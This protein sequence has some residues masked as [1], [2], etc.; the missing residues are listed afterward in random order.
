MS[1][2]DMALSLVLDYAADNRHGYELHGRH[3]DYG[4][5]CAGLARL[6]AA[7]VEE[8]SVATYPDFHTWTERSVLTARGWKCLPFSRS[9][10]RR[11]DILLHEDPT[12]GHGHT[13]IATGPE[14]IVGAEGN[15]DGR[16]GDSSGVEIWN[17]AYS[18]YRYGYQYILRPPEEEEMVEKKENG[19]YR[20]YDERS[21]LHVFTADHNEASTLVGMGWKEEGCE[22]K[23]G[24]L[25]QVHR[26]YN[27]YSGAHVQSVS[28]YE[29]GALVI[30]GWKYE[31]VSWKAPAAGRPVY[32]LYNKHN[33]DHML[34][35]EGEE[36]DS[37]IELGWS[38]DGELCKG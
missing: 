38:N 21:G 30:Q 29:V 36:M 10:M 7:A 22:I 18:D 31:G 12:G 11:G 19:I 9:A 27:P 20:L 17:R 35:F 33:G 6:Y 16:P 4:T 5:D 23:C 13:V 26:L 34:L 2:V 8:V 28:V 24:T 1:N 32:R 25:T 3:Y 37:L 14:T 15:W